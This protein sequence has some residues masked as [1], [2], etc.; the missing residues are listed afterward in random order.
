[1]TLLLNYPAV[2]STDEINVIEHIPA[3]IEPGWRSPSLQGT[4]EMNLK[5]QGCSHL[6]QRAAERLAVAQGA[7]G[8]SQLPDSPRTE[9]PLC[10]NQVLSQSTHVSLHTKE[11][12][13]RVVFM[14]TSTNLQQ[15]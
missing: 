4:W 1:M 2:V 9:A 7:P 13:C 10:S 11:H 5:H 3:H 14:F 12:C 15:S 8:W 6:A